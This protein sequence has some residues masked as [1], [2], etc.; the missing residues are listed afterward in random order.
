MAPQTVTLARSMAPRRPMAPQT[1]T[2]ARSMAPRKLTLAAPSA[3]SRALDIAAPGPRRTWVDSCP[4]GL[5]RPR[6]GPDRRPR[7]L[8]ARAPR[9]RGEGAQLLWAYPFL[10][11]ALLG[12]RG[13]YRAD[14]Y[15]PLLDAVAHI[16]G[17]AALTAMLLIAFVG[18][19]DPEARPAYLVGPVWLGGTLALIAGHA[20]LEDEKAGAGKAHRRESDP[21]RRRRPSGSQAGAPTDGAAS[22]RAHPDRLPRRGL[23]T[24]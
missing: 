7:R 15:R 4:D 10:T 23:R 1:V 22:P 3:R 16:A 17:V 9:P 11:I 12:L 6:P 13:L 14:H 24:L 19:T 2:L 5:R 18:I 21:D 8:D 20:T